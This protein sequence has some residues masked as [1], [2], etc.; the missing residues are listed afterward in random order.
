MIFGPAAHICLA[1]RNSVT[2]AADSVRFTG[3]MADMA[4]SAGLLPLASGVLEAICDFRL[5]GMPTLLAETG[6][7]GATLGWV[8]VTRRGCGA[9]VWTSGT[10]VGSGV[11]AGGAVVVAGT[12]V[13]LVAVESLV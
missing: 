1:C 8:D 2:R 4:A 7:G 12:M 11:A 9:T 5:N 3:S 13:A 10:L 6:C